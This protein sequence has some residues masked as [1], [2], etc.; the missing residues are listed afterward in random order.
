MPPKHKENF[1]Q[2][3]DMI[4]AYFEDF[5]ARPIIVHCS[6]GIGRTC[7][8]IGAFYLF[9]HWQLCRKLKQEFKFSVFK[10]VKHLR[11]YRW[12]AVQTLEQYTFLYELAASF[13]SF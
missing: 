13:I 1:L 11:G 7:T 8:L 4:G 6:A 9:D 2:V 10:L 3:L 12:R 5:K